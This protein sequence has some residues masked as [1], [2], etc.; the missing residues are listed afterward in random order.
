MKIILKNAD[1]S[2][3]HLLKKLLAPVITIEKKGEQ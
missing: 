3:N 2:K 1:F